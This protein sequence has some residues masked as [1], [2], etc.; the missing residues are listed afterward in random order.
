[1]PTKINPVLPDIYPCI[2]FVGL[3]GKNK[4]Q[5]KEGTLECNSSWDGWMLLDFYLLNYLFKSQ[6]WFTCLEPKFLVKKYDKFTHGN[7]YMVRRVVLDKSQMLDEITFGLEIGRDNVCT[8][9]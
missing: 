3:C 7:C 4:W 5:D 6:V 1:M 9:V 8:T 2:Y